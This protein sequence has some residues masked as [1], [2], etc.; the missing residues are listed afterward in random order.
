MNISL[1][2]LDKGRPGMT[3]THGADICEAATMCFRLQG[4]FSG[5][6]MT[7]DQNISSKKSASKCNVIWD[8]DVTDQMQRTW[9]PQNMTEPGACAVAILLIEELTEYTV[10]DLSYRG[11][12]FDYYLGKRRSP[13]PFKNSAR[14]EISGILKGNKSDFNRRVK[15]K[16]EQTEPSDHTGLPAYAVVVKFD[17]PISKVVEK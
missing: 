3:P 8:L 14:L 7:V 10:V 4:H 12:G 13:T 6:E 5:V 2:S 16:L 9:K 17:V 15:E 1:N 11:S